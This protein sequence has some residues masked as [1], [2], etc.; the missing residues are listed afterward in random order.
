MELKDT[1]DA[2]RE[3]LINKE[4]TIKMMVAAINSWEAGTKNGT[5]PDSNI[6][7][8][9]LQTD[10]TLLE[11]NNNSHTPGEEAPTSE[12]V[13]S[14]IGKLDAARAE[15]TSPTRR[16]QATLGGPPC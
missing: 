4:S 16:G 12:Q 10:V 3:L 15:F 14:F 2:L 8:G 9:R 5:P 1:Q 11:G 13:L 7:I 6:L